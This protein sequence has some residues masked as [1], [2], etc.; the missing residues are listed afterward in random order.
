[1][2]SFLKLGKCINCYLVA[3]KKT[4][5]KQRKTKPNQQKTKI[6]MKKGKK[7][8]KKQQTNHQTQNTQPQHPPGPD[9]STHHS[10]KLRPEESVALHSLKMTDGVMH[11]FC[12]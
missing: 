8:N 7:T 11:S 12:I 9:A 3:G 6:K 2:A 4:Q 1:M 5:Q 10:H